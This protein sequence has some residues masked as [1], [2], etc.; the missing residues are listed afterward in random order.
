MKQIKIKSIIN[1]LI[2]FVIIIIVGLIGSNIGYSKTFLFMVF[3]GLVFTFYKMFL[4]RDII[5]LQMRGAESKIFGK[6]LDKE[7]WNKNEL[8]NKKIKFVLIKPSEKK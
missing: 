1:V 2:P 4:A 6:P 3:A 5:L 7:Y 8:K